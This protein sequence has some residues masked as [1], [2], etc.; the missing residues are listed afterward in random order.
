MVKKL[1]SKR[2]LHNHYWTV[3]SKLSLIMYNAYVDGGL[4]GF[5]RRV[6][7]FCHHFFCSHGLHVS[8]NLCSVTV[9][10]VGAGAHHD[11]FRKLNVTTTPWMNQLAW[12]GLWRG[13]RRS[14]WRPLCI[15]NHGI[16]H[17]STVTYNTEYNTEDLGFYPR[18]CKQQLW[19]LILNRAERERGRAR[20]H[21]RH[22]SK[23]I[24]CMAVSCTRLQNLLFLKHW[25]SIWNSLFNQ[26][27][28][29]WVELLEEA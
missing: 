17:F 2:A 7:M 19:Q 23:W 21:E 4:S 10:K 20:K 6:F 22:T 5:G 15:N 11:T 29:H 27:W 28:V 14:C 24:S 25:C 26:E 12:R 9:A 3:R 16:T 8:E 1:S 18:M 13:S